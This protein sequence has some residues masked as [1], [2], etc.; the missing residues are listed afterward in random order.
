MKKILSLILALSMTFALVA[1]G[2]DS[3][4]GEADREIPDT[5]AGALL[6]EFYNIV[7]AN[8]EATA[9]EIAEKLSTHESIPF[10]SMAMPVEPGLQMGFNNYEITGFAEGAAFAPMMNAIAFIGYI[11]TLEDGADVNAFMDNLKANANPRWNICVAAEETLVS[12]V[13]NKV[14]FVMSPLY[15][16]G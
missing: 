2:G 9:F 12:N 4:S 14:F 1:C 16:E 13:G 5:A 3:G 7:D 6:Q 10:M 8:P 11:F 15:L